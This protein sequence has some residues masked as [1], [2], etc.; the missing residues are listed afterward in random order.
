MNPS[1]LAKAR[2]PISCRPCKRGTA[3]KPPTP[4]THPS[5]STVADP[6]TKPPV[7]T[8]TKQKRDRKANRSYLANV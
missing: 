6:K 5:M 8:R 3:I 4:T 1:L 2:R 7:K